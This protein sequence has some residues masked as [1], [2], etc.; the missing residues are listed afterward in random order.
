MSSTDKISSR[1]YDIPKLSN[2]G[3]NFQTWKY[4]ITTIL[5]LRKLIDITNG[6]EAKPATNATDNLKQE[7]WLRRDQDVLVQI[8]LT[9]DD[10]LL[11]I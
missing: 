8:I 5:T 9:I 11:S 7:D 6:K 2:D 3:S 1:L 4:H 10:E